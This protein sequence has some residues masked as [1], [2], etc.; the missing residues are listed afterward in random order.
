MAKN[1]F[2]HIEFYVTDL[3]RARR[4]YEGLFE[5]DFRDF[6]GEHF[7]M[8]VFG[9]GDQH[10]GGLLRTDSAEPASRPQV[11]IE[12][13]ILENY[14]TKAEGF[15][16]SVLSPRSEVPG[17]GFSAVLADP[18]GNPVGLVEFAK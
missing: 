6:G 14:T 7:D 10:L 5:W 15:G 1:T 8:L 13:D 17:V 16:G 12:A 4:F 2:C 9:K 11:W 3:P 18:D